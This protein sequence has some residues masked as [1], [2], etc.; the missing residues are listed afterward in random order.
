M[1]Q[2]KLSESDRERVRYHLGYFSTEP[3]AAIVSGRLSATQPMFIVEAAMDRVIAAAIP[4][5]RHILAELDCVEEQMSNARSR[6]A[7]QRI[8]DVTF[9][10]TN[11]GRTECDLLENEYA[12]WASRLADQ[13]GVPINPNSMRYRE[14]RYGSIAEGSVPVALPR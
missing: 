14:G 9:R 2:P 1:T 3:V 12:R 7:V 6:L 13:L 5:V 8:E 4:R 10:S 11:D